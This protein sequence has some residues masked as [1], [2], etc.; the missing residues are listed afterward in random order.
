MTIEYVP[1][2]ERD[3][4]VVDALEVNLE[5]GDRVVLRLEANRFFASVSRSIDSSTRTRR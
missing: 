5:G 2:D 3:A 1:I 4:D